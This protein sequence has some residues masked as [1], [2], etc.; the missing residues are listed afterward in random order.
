MELKGSRTEQNLLNAFSGESMARNK[1][2]FFAEKAKQENHP[3][4]AELFEKMAQNEGMHGKLLYHYLK[5]VG[6]TAENL[7]EAVD[8]EYGEW[9]RMYPEF[10]RIAREEGFEAIGKLFDEITKIER[11]HEGRFL[12][13]LAKLHNP[14]VDT[15]K[16]EA[17]PKNSGGK[18]MV[19]VSGYHCMFCAPLMSIVRMSARYV[20]QLDRLSPPPSRR[21]WRT[22]FHQD[23]GRQEPALT[24][25]KF[26]VY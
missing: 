14:S 9:S 20:R 23:C 24:N 1:Y 10:A 5:G 12:M 8:G 15:S 11:D 13:A 22:E 21:K 16:P 3:E 6:G 7:R 26:V 25:L 2:L 19:T 4:V 17:A 18:H